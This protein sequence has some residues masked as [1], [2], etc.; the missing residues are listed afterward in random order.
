MYL[1]MPNQTTM[2]SYNS[3]H[4]AVKKIAVPNARKRSQAVLNAVA[5][6]L[7]FLA[8]LAAGVQST[9]RLC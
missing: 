6:P 4:G 9:K 8:Q 1:L 5:Y 7:Y 2:T 3:I